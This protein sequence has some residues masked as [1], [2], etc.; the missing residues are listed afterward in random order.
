MSKIQ[1]VVA[2]KLS[3]IGLPHNHDTLVTIEQGIKDELGAAALGELIG[4]AVGR[5]N[6][7]YRRVAEIIYQELERNNND[8]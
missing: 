3:L 4:R 8:V 7:V 2:S 6:F 5:P 1:T